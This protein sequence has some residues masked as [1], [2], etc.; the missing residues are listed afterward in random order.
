MEESNESAKKYFSLVCTESYKE[1][2]PKDKWVKCSHFKLLSHEDC[3][4]GRFSYEKYIIFIFIVLVYRLF[5]FRN[6]KT[7]LL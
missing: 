6:K 7:C 4:D 2:K 3:R 1:S 5:S